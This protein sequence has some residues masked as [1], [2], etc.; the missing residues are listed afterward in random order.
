MLKFNAQGTHW[1][2]ITL[3]PQKEIFYSFQTTPENE[4]VQVCI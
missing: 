2:Q 3:G 4:H 1:Y